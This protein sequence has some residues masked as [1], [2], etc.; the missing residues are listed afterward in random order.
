[1]KCE[2]FIKIKHTYDIYYS[3]SKKNMV[4]RG[5]FKNDFTNII[6]LLKY[7]KFENNLIIL[8]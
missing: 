7:F 1:M 8:K 6:N 2:N 3:E 4:K 5:L